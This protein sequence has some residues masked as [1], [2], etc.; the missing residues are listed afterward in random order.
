VKKEKKE[1]GGAK[2]IKYIRE[3]QKRNTNTDPSAR[4][5]RKVSNIWNVVF[6]K[7]KRI[8]YTSKFK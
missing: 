5:N 8:I 4:S 3:E 2:K 1:R 6:N 7:N